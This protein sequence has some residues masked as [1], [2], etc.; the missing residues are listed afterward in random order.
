MLKHS[1]A[2][3]L[4]QANSTRSNLETAGHLSVLMKGTSYYFEILNVTH[5][6]TEI[7]ISNEKHAAG[8]VFFKD[9]DQ[10]LSLFDI[11]ENGRE[12]QETSNDCHGGSSQP[13]LYCPYGFYCGK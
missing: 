1:E 5:V 8:W 12:L 2:S 6:L 4:E 11:R 7:N 13:R 10:V 9:H 3:L